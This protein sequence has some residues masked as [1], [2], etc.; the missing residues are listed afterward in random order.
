[1]LTPAIRATPI[2]LA[3][4]LP[5]GKGLRYATAE[6]RLF[7]TRSITC[8]NDRTRNSRGK[9]APIAAMSRV[10]AVFSGISARRQPFRQVYFGSSPAPTTGQTESCAAISK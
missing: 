3:F 10:G 7:I 5:Y 1:M 8:Q 9:S 6:G 2:L 4:H